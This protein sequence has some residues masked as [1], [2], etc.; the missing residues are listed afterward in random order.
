MSTGHFGG[1]V[2]DTF[3]NPIEQ[4][5]C[6]GQIRPNMASKK[7]QGRYDIPV[8]THFKCKNHKELVE[9]KLRLIGTLDFFDNVHA[10]DFQQLDYIDFYNVYLKEFAHKHYSNTIK[11]M[12]FI[13]LVRELKL[14]DHLPRLEELSRRKT[15]KEDLK[16]F[17]FKLVDRDRKSVV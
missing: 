2:A 15:S 8:H 14:F 6:F 13:A 1:I 7:I 5:L 9:G 4:K 17:I 10:I 11:R 16:A 3:E 12:Q